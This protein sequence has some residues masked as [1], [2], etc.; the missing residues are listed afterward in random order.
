[1]KRVSQS[2]R[3]LGKL[4]AHARRAENGTTLIVTPFIPATPDSAHAD[5]FESLDKSGRVVSIDLMCADNTLPV[6]VF[7]E[8]FGCKTLI[9]PGTSQ[10]QH[11]VRFV[12]TPQRTWEV[13]TAALTAGMINSHA[14]TK[15]VY[16]G[17]A[18]FTI[19]NL[20][21]CDLD[22]KSYSMPN[23][24]GTDVVISTNCPSIDTLYKVTAYR[25]QKKELEM[26][27]AAVCYRSMTHWYL[28][29]L[30][31]EQTIQ[32]IQ[33]QVLDVPVIDFPTSELKM[34]RADGHP[35]LL[36]QDNTLTLSLR[37]QL[38]FNYMPLLVGSE[39]SESEPV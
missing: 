11:P 27:V 28:P 16:V 1:M 15:Y 13:D 38:M 21:E 22:L 10:K 32:F 3:L 6:D 29:S 8:L 19:E 18:T 35:L 37:L 24:N 30:E 17:T 12:Q 14:I 39:E 25:V 20:L 23:G 9:Q 26:R 33:N 2:V 5:P 34:A 7:V 4:D 31:L 36:D